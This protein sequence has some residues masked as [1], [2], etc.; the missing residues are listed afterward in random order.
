MK[1]ITHESTTFKSFSFVSPQTLDDTL[2]VASN[3]MD[4]RARVVAKSQKKSLS[5]KR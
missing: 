2:A 3:I 4:V 5:S 1:K